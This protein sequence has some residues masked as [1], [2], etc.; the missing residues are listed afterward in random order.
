MLVC[1]QLAL[2]MEC[3]LQVICH[4]LG[5]VAIENRRRLG[6]TKV[7]GVPLCFWEF[8]PR[9]TLRLLKSVFLIFLKYR[10]ALLCLHPQKVY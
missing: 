7:A 8:T 2:A 5:N 3:K 10:Q 9:G 4:E 1:M 6:Y